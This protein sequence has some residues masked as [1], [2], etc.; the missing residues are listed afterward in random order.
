MAGE[1]LKFKVLE[2]EGEGKKV[3][4]IHGYGGNIEQPGVKWLMNRFEDSGYS[5]TYIQLPTVINDFKEDILQPL[6]DVQDTLGDHVIVGFSIGA[7]AAAYLNKQKSTIYMSPFWGINDRWAFKGLGTL[8]KVIANLN[9]PALKRHFEKEDAGPMAVDEDMNGIPDYV[10]PRTIH[11][12]HSAHNNMP[13]PNKD[14]IMFYC[15][16]DAVV[17]LKAIKRRD[18]RKITFNGGHMFYLSRERDDI[19]DKVLSYVEE[20]F[21]QSHSAN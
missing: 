2:M 12:M 18:I 1:P 11:E 17:S 20:G 6:R 13:E 19:M 4:F 15:P 14:D 9:K 8:L 21:S 3:L 16:N 5:V 7:L 10:T